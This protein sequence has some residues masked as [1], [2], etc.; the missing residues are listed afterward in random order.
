MAYPLTPI[1]SVAALLTNWFSCV[2]KVSVADRLVA[3]SVASHP[4]TGF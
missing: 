2:D 3:K 4:K 1:D